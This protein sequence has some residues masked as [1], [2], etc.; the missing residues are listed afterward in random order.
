MYRLTYTMRWEHFSRNAAVLRYNFST[1]RKDTKV[2][3]RVVNPI[4]DVGG[5]PDRGTNE[6]KP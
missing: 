1:E 2:T 3:F 4:A 5:T 6:T